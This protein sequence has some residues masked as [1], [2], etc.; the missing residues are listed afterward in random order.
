MKKLV[1]ISILLFLLIEEVSLSSTFSVD[2]A[3]RKNEL[4]SILRNGI[5]VT[6]LT[7]SFESSFSPPQDRQQVAF[8][9]MIKELRNLHGQIF[10]LPYSADFIRNT[11]IPEVNAQR[12][13]IAP[14]YPERSAYGDDGEL[15]H[16][17]LREWFETYPQE[18][19]S[20]IEYLK[21]FIDSHNN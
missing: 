5:N 11:I 9:N 2:I 6:V 17:M 4:Q 12:L 18:C 8:E 13:T 1:G 7:S 14:H 21:S 15:A 20:Y 3:S 16:N 10:N 19:T